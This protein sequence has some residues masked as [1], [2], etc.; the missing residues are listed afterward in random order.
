MPDPVARLN[1]A[2]EGRYRIESELGEGG[3][4]TVYLADDL[5]H[6][7]K[8]ALKVLKPELAAVVGAERFLAEIK[9]TANLQHPHILPLHDSGEADGFLFYV[10]PFVEGESLRERLDRE[11]QL[12]VDETVQIA[13]NVAEALDYAHKQGV[14]HRDIKPANILLQA[15]KPVISDFGIALAVGVAGG[16]RL[17]ETGLSLGTPHYMSPEQATGDLNVGTATDIYALGCVLYE[18]LVGEPPY[19]GSTPQAILG[20]IIARESPSVAA[21]RSAVPGNVDAAVHV[22]L[23]KTPADRFPTIGRFAEALNAPSFTLP[24]RRSPPAAS[25]SLRRYAWPSTAVAAAVLAVFGWVRTPTIGMTTRMQISLPESQRL[26]RSGGQTYALDISRDGSRLVYIGEE[27]GETRLYLRHLDSFDL[28]ALPGTERARQPFFSP[29]GAWVGFFTESELRRVS[30]SG[31]API[32]VARLPE[33]N[34]GGA[35]WGVDQTILYC[36]GESVYSVP[37]AGGEPVEYPLPGVLVGMTGREDQADIV[38]VRPL[39]PHFLPGGEQALV[40][41]A[42]VTAVL[43]LR[44]GEYRYLFAGGQARYLPTGHLLYN[45]GQ[46]RALLVPFDLDRMELQG[47]SIPAAEDVFRGPG[48]GAL[49]LAV[50]DNGTLVFVRGGFERTL[51]LVDRNGR[52]TPVAV[53]PRGYRFP[54]LSRDGVRLAVT[55]DPRP[56]DLWIVDLDRGIAERQPTEDHDGWGVWAPD[57]NRLAFYNSTNPRHLWV[58]DYPFVDPAV[59]IGGP[60]HASIFPLSWTPDDRLLASGGGRITAVSIADGTVQD[61]INDAFEAIP[62][63]SPNGEWVAYV[64]DLTGV[65]EVYAVAYPEPDERHLVSQGGGTD[66]N[67]SSDGTELFYRSGNSI[68]A[69]NVRTSPLF[70]VLS[71]PITLFS[72][73]YDFFQDGNWTVRPNGQFV[74]IRSDPTNSRQLRVVLNWFKELKDRVPN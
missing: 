70:E 61:L 63:I 73:P 13:K 37:V 52:E 17:T 26:G 41:L 29:D 22:A 25:S 15:G 57:G 4:A 10:M 3:M 7:R 27:D 49:N 36:V 32:R 62:R 20:K 71:E 72:I 74:M 45:G 68:M 6:E 55:V 38:G 50:S 28:Q 43:D 65:N 8:V 60:D 66:P 19:T 9:T 2:L 54:R 44:S 31:G 47:P 48:G 33:G 14:I 35:S 23:S 42:S 1:A 40:T 21:E 67:W 58:R 5:K 24:T 64:S 56:S 69:V 18:M 30:V 46:E 59:P 12:P 34:S 51:V 53:D 11:H 16:R 39:W